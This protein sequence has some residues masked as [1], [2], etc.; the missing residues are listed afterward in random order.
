MILLINGVCFFTSCHTVTN[1]MSNGCRGL[2]KTPDW[3]YIVSSIS[4][5]ISGLILIFPLP[6]IKTAQELHMIPLDDPYSLPGDRQPQFKVLFYQG[7]MPL[8]QRLLHYLAVFA[9]VGSGYVIAAESLMNTDKKA[10]WWIELVLLVISGAC[11]LLFFLK[12]LYRSWLQKETLDQVTVYFEFLG[13]FYYLV[14]T[15]L[16]A[17]VTGNL[18]N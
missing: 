18:F 11:I 9:G 7:V 12:E 16:G 15:V 6:V 14:A 4:P 3:V 1:G 5:L 8:Y 2:G 10:G 17:A 13:L